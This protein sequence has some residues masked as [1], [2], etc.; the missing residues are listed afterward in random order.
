MQS[1]TIHFYATNPQHLGENPEATLSYAEHN[2]ICGDDITVYLQIEENRIKKWSFTGNTSM[3]T[4]ACSGLFG[5][6]VQSVDFETL[7]SWNQSTIVRETGITVSPRRKRA[8]VL[9]LLATRNALHEY[10]QD[11]KKDDFSDVLVD[12]I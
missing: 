12:E 3:I 9:A 5:D 7:F 2:R 8:Q 10:L 6:L 1:E 4:L 11:G